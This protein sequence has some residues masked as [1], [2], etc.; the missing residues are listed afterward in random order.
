MYHAENDNSFLSENLLKN[1]QS[2]TSITEFDD[3]DPKDIKRI[4][5]Y[6]ALNGFI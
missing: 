3:E 5:D 4:F 2:E 1:N 6:I